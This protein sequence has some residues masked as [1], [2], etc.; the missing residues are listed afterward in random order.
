V[1]QRIL[2]FTSS[3]EGHSNV[4]GNNVLI[5]EA[6]DPAQP[7]RS[8]AEANC[9]EYAAIWDTGATHSAITEKVIQECGLNPIGV[10]EVHYGSGP[11]RSNQYVVDIW[12]PNKAVI[13]S[14]TVTKANIASADV[15]IGMDIIGSGDFAVSNFNNKTKFTFRVPSVESIDFVGKPFK[16]RPSMTLPRGKR[17]R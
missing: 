1:A 5:S 7:P 16:P 11:Q 15:I 17:R 2:S 4:L 8:P 14:V 6:T 3:Y 13:S 12:L 9:R 10:V